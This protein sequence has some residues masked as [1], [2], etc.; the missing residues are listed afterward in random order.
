MGKITIKYYLEKR[1]TEINGKFPL[2]IQIIANQKSTQIKSF[3]NVYFSDKDFNDFLLYDIEK[4]KFNDLYMNLNEDKND[5]ENILNYCI[6][7]KGIKLGQYKIKDLFDFY[8]QET[9]ATIG[10]FFYYERLEKLIKSNKSTQS[11]IYILRPA[12]AP[13]R[14]IN[15]MKTATNVDLSNLDK[16]TKNELDL[17]NRFFNITDTRECVSIICLYNGIAK[18]KILESKDKDAVSIWEYVAKVANQIES[19]YFQE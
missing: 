12:V 19:D 8:G 14:F 17:I 15:I 2:Y 18:T 10:L 7:T 5:L 11:L 9:S 4:D 13:Q 6:N 1:K 16:E 3:E